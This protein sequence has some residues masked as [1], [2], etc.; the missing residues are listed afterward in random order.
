VGSHQVT[1]AFTPANP[2]N[3]QSSTSAAVTVTVTRGGLLA[4]VQ[5]LLANLLG[6]PSL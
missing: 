2:A 4:V 6:V 1:A 5:I 3:F